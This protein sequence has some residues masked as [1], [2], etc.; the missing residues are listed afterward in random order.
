MLCVGRGKDI[1]KHWDYKHLLSWTEINH[2]IPNANAS[3]KT[4]GKKIVPTN[5]VMTF[6]IK[7]LLRCLWKEELFLKWHGHDTESQNMLNVSSAAAP[8]ISS[9]WLLYNRNMKP[10]RAKTS[11]T[12][13]IVN[14]DNRE[15]LKQSET[16]K[17]V[18]S[19]LTNHFLFGICQD[20]AIASIIKL[21]Q[22][23][24]FT[25]TSQRIIATWLTPTI[26]LD[27]WCFQG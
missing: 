19:K 18:G 5:F 6:S 25:R 9:V 14:K 15:P 2:P 20:T 17:A 26:S 21:G 3:G 8:S 4:V 24:T 1:W 10:S 13:A 7:H 16:Y 11:H 27:F 12:P 22:W 23:T